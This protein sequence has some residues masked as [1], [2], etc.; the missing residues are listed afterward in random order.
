[1]RRQRR[2]CLAAMHRGRCRCRAFAVRAHVQWA[3][4]PLVRRCRSGRAASPDHGPHIRGRPRRRRGRPR[5]GSAGRHGLRPSP[6]GGWRSGSRRGGRRCRGRP[7]PRDED[8]VAGVDGDARPRDEV[9]D[10][11]LGCVL[12]LEAE[13]QRRQPGVMT[14]GSDLHVEAV[15]SRRCECAADVVLPDERH[16]SRGPAAMAG[17]PPRRS[18]RTVTGE[19][20]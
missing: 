19:D 20:Q 18:L 12:A 11:V 1:M 2:P 5:P 4:V 15:D 16:S 6:P 7:L 14:G 13:A 8:A 3:T 17:D 9:G 10:V